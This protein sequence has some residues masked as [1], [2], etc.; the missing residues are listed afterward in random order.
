MGV[1]AKTVALERQVGQG[2]VTCQGPFADYNY[3]ARRKSLQGGINE[4]RL[5][6][7]CRIVLAVAR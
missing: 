4:G 5:K 6:T 7:S 2:F 3:M 1:C